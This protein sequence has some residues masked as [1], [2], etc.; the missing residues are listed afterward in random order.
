MLKLVPANVLKLVSV[1]KCV[2][3]GGHECVE[4]G[5]Q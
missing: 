5:G 4:A 1:V 3:A 2:E